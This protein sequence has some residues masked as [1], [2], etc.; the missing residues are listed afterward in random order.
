MV[1]TLC[2]SKNKARTTVYECKEGMSK[3]DNTGVLEFDLGGSSV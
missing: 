2:L 3:D 1:P